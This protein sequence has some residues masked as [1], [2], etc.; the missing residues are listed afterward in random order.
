[1][2]A[3]YFSGFIPNIMYNAFQIGSLRLLRLLGHQFTQILSLSKI[4]MSGWPSPSPVFDGLFKS[5]WLPVK[6]SFSYFSLVQATFIRLDIVFLLSFDQSDFLWLNWILKKTVP[7]FQ[8]SL[9]YKGSKKNPLLHGFT[10]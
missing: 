10:R 2:K 9:G 3:G 4:G 7:I 1:M 8:F 6:S 5:L